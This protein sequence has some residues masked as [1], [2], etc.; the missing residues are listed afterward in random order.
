MVDN[1]S[2]VVEDGSSVVDKR[3]SINNWGSFNNWSSFYY[4]SSSISLVGKAIVIAVW[5]SIVVSVGKTIV[6]TKGVRVGNHWGVIYK[7]AVCLTMAPNT[8]V[9]V[10]ISSSFG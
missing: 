7:G 4:W 5:K 2:G 3:S 10:A 1:G 8:A 6:I 9:V